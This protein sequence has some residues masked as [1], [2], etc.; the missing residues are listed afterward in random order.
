MGK[1]WYTPPVRL[2]LIALALLLPAF[3]T[4]FLYF[5]HTLSGLLP[6][7]PGALG[8]AL[9]L[10]FIKGALLILLAG[11]T[12]I[13]WLIYRFYSRL[14]VFQRQTRDIVRSSALASRIAV[15]GS[16]EFAALAADL[17][18]V[19]ERTQ[20]LAISVRQAGDSIAHDLRTPLTRMRVDV[21]VVLQSDDAEAWHATLER[22][23][24]EVDGMQ[25]TFNSLLALGQ[26]EAGGMRLKPNDVN[27]SRLLE[28]IAEL[29]S[30]SAEEH[31]LTLQ[32]EV[33]EGIQLQGDKQLL[34]QTF[35]NLLD[36][37]MKYVPSG[38]TIR[39]SA[40]L[41]GKNAVVA[42]EDNGPG[43][44]EEM[45]DKVF[46]RF[47]RIDPSR[48]LPGTGLGLALVKAF[49][50]LHRGTIRIEQSAMGGAAFK[51]TLPV[52]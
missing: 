21:E 42:V 34:A 25:T 1:A 17:N 26:A 14:E 15:N 37:A 52:S 12:V 47:T 22:I 49:V 50:E 16:D 46:E 9:R 35:S 10:T 7:V 36:N 45:R 24:A 48:T 51:I 2:A 11:C 31:E 33:Q 27:L 40:V 20:K 29:Y 3:L 32:V 5:N 4:V 30:P 41:Q 28:E 38:G 23:L 39:L 13:F 6:G 44:P 43:I 18:S 19:L 8:G